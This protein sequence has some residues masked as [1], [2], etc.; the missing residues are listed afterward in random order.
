MDWEGHVKTASLLSLLFAVWLF[1]S[2]YVMGF[3][4]RSAVAM[5]TVDIA[6][7]G[8]FILSAIR[9]WIPHGTRVLSWINVLVGLG[10][11]LSPFVWFLTGDFYLMWDFVIV[12]AALV[13]F[14]VWAALAHRI[15]A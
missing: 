1:I 5:W 15:A 3:A 4:T 9:L 14:N 13:V 11:M 2:P 7:V 8:V 12:G 10:L 6:G